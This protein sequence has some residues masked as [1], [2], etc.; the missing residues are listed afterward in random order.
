MNGVGDACKAAAVGL[1][2]SRDALV[3]APGL[4]EI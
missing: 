4:F 2:R 1:L 3:D